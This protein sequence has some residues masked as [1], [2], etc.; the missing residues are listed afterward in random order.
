[1]SGSTTRLGLKTPVDSDP[2]L[3]LDFTNNYQ[4]IDS[5]P[6]VFVCTSGTLPSWG[7][8][9]AG[10]MVFQ[11]DVRTL[12]EWSGSSWQ[13]PLVAP[14]AWMV[15]VTL[16]SL[17]TGFSSV[18]WSV[19]TISSSRA[20]QALFITSVE[21][22][23]VEGFQDWWSSCTPNVNGSELFGAWG[24]A[25]GNA[26]VWSSAVYNPNG[27]ATSPMS[28]TSFGIGT[29]NAGYNALGV[30]IQV[31]NNGYPGTTGGPAVSLGGLGTPSIHIVNA[32]VAAVMINS[33]AT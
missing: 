6:G 9:Q 17:V 30:N 29:L 27:V 2:F 13:E 8:A 16:N 19:G 28:A 4:T 10:Q 24:W 1:M 3:T 25:S 7:A 5:Y 22:S 14:S 31:A 21:Y 32:Y 18:N 20:G 26:A 23:L 15:G 12:L 33:T 11:S